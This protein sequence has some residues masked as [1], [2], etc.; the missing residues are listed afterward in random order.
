[1][2]NPDHVALAPPRLRRRM[3]SSDTWVRA[4]IR[5]G[6]TVSG[7]QLQTRLS[8]YSMLADSLGMLDRG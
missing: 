8:R 3:G 5:A 6:S 7:T 1:M 4:H 2:P